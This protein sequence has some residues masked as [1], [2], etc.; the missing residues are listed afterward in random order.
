MPRPIFSDKVYALSK[1][2]NYPLRPF[3]P[4]LERTAAMPHF[5]IPAAGPNWRKQ[6]AALA[7]FLADH[8][9]MVLTGA[10]ISTE[11]GIPDYRGE[12]TRRRARSPITW[13]EFTSSSNQ[14]KRY[15]ARSLVGWPHMHGAQ[16]NPAHSA[17][18][19][20]ERDGRISGVV[21]QNVDG[22]HQKGGSTGV[23]ELHG[24]L[25]EVICLSCGQTEN[26]ELLQAR[27]LQMNPTFARSD[28]WL[29][30]DGDRDRDTAEDLSSFCPPECLACGGP[31]KPRVVFFGESVPAHIVA[32]AYARLE[33]SDSL[34]IVG[35]SLAVF[36]GYRFVKRAAKDGKAI[37][38]V[39]L[40]RVRGEEL[41]SCRVEGR[42]AEVM[43]LLLETLRK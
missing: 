35:S 13:S 33:S 16:P 21:T 37:A 30:A 14:R 17:L 23:I 12:E 1:M 43:A 36:S 7:D 5:P 34:W 8:R 22:L 24:S 9:P 29:R 3:V 6:T 10:G 40:G 27:L 32:A 4:R 20:L 25:H 31:L 39:D 26:R 18:A 2:T 38:L 41:A 19:E 15:W 42:A 11:S 28:G